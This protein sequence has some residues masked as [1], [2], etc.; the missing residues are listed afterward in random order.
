MF[1]SITEDDEIEV[2]IK[3]MKDILSL[4]VEYEI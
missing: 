3:E 1:A 2:V 4:E